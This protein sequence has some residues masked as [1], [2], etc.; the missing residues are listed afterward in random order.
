[1]L[2]FSSTRMQRL[3]T[4]KLSMTLVLLLALNGDG[5]D[6]AAAAT[7][8]AAAGWGAGAAG[9]GPSPDRTSDTSNCIESSSRLQQRRLQEV[10]GCKK[11]GMMCDLNVRTTGVPGGPRTAALSWS[12]EAPAMLMKYIRGLGV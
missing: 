11:G 9:A 3:K 5:D 12:V 7:A 2:Q 8:A 4:H 6:S 1:M 10:Y